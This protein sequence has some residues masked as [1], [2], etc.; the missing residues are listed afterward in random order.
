ME[1]IVKFILGMFYCLL[2]LIVFF[3]VVQI[4]CQ[5]S[6]EGNLQLFQGNTKCFVHG[7]QSKYNILLIPWVF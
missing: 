2:K 5:I 7:F 6:Y 3:K 4:L 1:N